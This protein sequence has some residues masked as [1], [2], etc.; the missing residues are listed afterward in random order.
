MDKQIVAANSACS[1]TGSAK[2]YLTLGE[3]LEQINGT[4]ILGN[5]DYQ[6]FGLSVPWSAKEA[7][8]CVVAK[9]ADLKEVRPDVCSV[10]TVQAYASEL[11]GVANVIVVEDAVQ[12]SHKL[13]EI[14][15]DFYKN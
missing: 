12:A 10:V 14:F 2:D 5:A 7:D 15:T 8:L 9:L 13:M 6:I 3:I 1:S 4:L 11:H